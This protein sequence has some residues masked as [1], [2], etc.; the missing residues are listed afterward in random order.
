METGARPFAFH[1]VRLG[2]AQPA[3]AA[4]REETTMGN[5]LAITRPAYG[6]IAETLSAVVTIAG[7]IQAGANP[8]HINWAALA[9]DAHRAHLALQAARALPADEEDDR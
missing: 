8:N 4:P 7:M 3:P 1:P 9:E 5:E 6:A 2:G